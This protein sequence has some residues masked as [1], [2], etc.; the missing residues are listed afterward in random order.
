MGDCALPRR[1]P[2]RFKFTARAAAQSTEIATAAAGASALAK[3][4]DSKANPYPRSAPRAKLRD[5]QLSGRS[6]TFAGLQA[7][8]NDY[9]T[10][11]SLFCRSRLHAIRY[12]PLNKPC[13]PYWHGYSLRN[14]PTSYRWKSTTRTSTSKEAQLIQAAQNAVKYG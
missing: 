12:A 4:L 3:K 1:P 5:G 7:V 13:K 8:Q 6:Q 2:H 11:M 10:S 9:R 14:F